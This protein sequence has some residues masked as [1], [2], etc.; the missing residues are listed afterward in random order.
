MPGKKR[1]ALALL[2][3][4]SVALSLCCGWRKK[5]RGFLVQIFLGGEQKTKTAAVGRR[6]P[7]RRRAELCR[8][9]PR[10]QRELGQRRR[11]PGTGLPRAGR[12]PWL[13]RRASGG[14]CGCRDGG[15]VGVCEGGRQRRERE[16]R[17]LTDDPWACSEKSWYKC[18]ILT[19]THTY[20][21]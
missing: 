5:K 14:P 19:H 13:S 2:N 10:E 21:P 1:G 7:R 15:E 16:R 3:Y 4:G 18:I 8:Y 11:E 12:L 17:A 6:A 9:L 20:H